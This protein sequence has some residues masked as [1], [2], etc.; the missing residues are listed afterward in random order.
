MLTP[1]ELNARAGLVGSDPVLGGISAAVRSRVERLL[2]EPPPLPAQ[3]AL[4]SRAGGTCPHDGAPLRFDPWQPTAHTCTRCG[5][6]S[7]GERHEGHWARAGH[8]WVAER[9]AD[10]ATL[11]TLEGDEAAAARARELL[12]KTATIYQDLPNRD[13]VLGPTHLFFSTYLESLWIT[14]W[15]AGALILRQA[16]LLDD[17]T[18]AAADS[19][20]E[21]SATIIGEFNEGLSNR[22]VWN[23]TALVAL[24]A[25]FGDEELIQ[26]SVESRT[27]LLGLLTDGFQGREGT[28]WE[29]ENYHLF[30]ARGLTIGLSWARLAGFDLLAEDELRAHYRNAMLAPSLTALP[31]L[32]YPAR[33]DSRYGVSLAQ[34]AHLETW[35]VAR[36]F[37]DPDPQ[38]DAW[39]HALYATK[40][41]PA[42]QY[43][44]WLHD[45]GL[46][47]REARRRVD[48]SWWAL[49]MLDPRELDTSVTHAS[50]SIALPAQGL[51]ILRHGE[52]YASLECGT[53]GGGHGHPDRLH[54]TLHAEG[55]HW[56]PDPGTGSYVDR[57]LFWYRDSRAHNAPTIGGESPAD[58]KCLAFE[59]NDA[60]GWVRGSAGSATRSIVAGPGLLVDLLET[61]AGP[62]VVEL[63]WHLQGTWNLVT[64]GKWQPAD[65]GD[66]SLAPEQFVPDAAGPLVVESER[67][68]KRIRLH[69][70]GAGELL[71]AT[72]PGL[73]GTNTPQPFLIR[74]APGGSWLGAVLDVAADQATSVE[75]NAGG[76]T[77]A[78]PSG[79]TEVA[80]APTR[81]TIAHAGGKVTLTGLRE[82]RIIPPP[83]IADR[84]AW[85]A[86][87]LAPQAWSTPALDGS[88]EGF[89]LDH[90]LTLDDE[91]QYRRSEEPYD[92]ER[93]SAT[94][95]LNWDQHGLY[96]AVEV[97]KPEIVLRDPDA[98]PLDLDNEADDIHQDGLQIYLRYP[99][100]E[101]AGFV[102]V[103]DASGSVR[104]R[105]VGEDQGAAVEGVW[106]E[107]EG[108]YAATIAIR[109]QRFQSLRPGETLGFDLVVNEMTS[110]RVR[111]LGQLVWSGDGG[112]T[113]LRGDRG[114]AGGVV[115]LG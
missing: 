10:L 51:A 110:D 111:R 97:R 31:D 23:S 48:L 66:A 71:R 91:H 99:E 113:Y 15:L 55:V 81:A 64:P 82:T 88:F 4:L 47:E 6:V 70:F 105:P 45:A 106:G 73:P 24:G 8:L 11:A 34:P 108:G 56:L 68:G 83:L 85:Q 41:R 21:E 33:K 75:W 109:D 93:L 115:E 60:W 104:A 96:L 59:S 69:L 100:G 13:N 1:D 37:L 29:G 52:Q 58:A 54:L 98:A 22:Q 5:R 92:P 57:S 84:P 36:G 76:V 50:P 53:A 26:N 3:K 14:S 112:W 103:P 35:E 65:L 79:R 62:G 102:V 61:T 74:R 94:A 80:I 46:P 39:L 32:T 30:A 95:W 40:P 2:R 107:I 44:A 9:I 114:A 89:D 17:A 27:G 18:A 63:P 87:T 86:R 77:I 7:S 42:D 43:D 20:A 90:P 101:T 72:G 28:W 25:W 78:R 19:V 67:E 16:E 49:L 12:I 38:L